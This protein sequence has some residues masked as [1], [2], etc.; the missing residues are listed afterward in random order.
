MVWTPSDWSVSL[1]L[2]H[3]G[4]DSVSSHQPHDCLLN[5]LFS[6]RSKKISKLRVTGLCAGNSP[7][8]GEFSA[9]M[10]SNAENVPIWWRHHDMSAVL[11]QSSAV[12][13]RS[14]LLR[15]N[16]RHCDD[17]G[18]TQIKLKLTTDTPY[19]ALTSELWC[20]YC[21]DFVEYWPRDINTALHVR[22]NVSPNLAI[23]VSEAVLAFK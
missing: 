3:N 6:R 2:R 10:V 20:V 9:Q 16:I 8:T 18:R 21:E 14:N 5:R 12:M 17:R 23:A 4:H 22:K 19:F 11:S 7:E 13:T 15:Y 1:H